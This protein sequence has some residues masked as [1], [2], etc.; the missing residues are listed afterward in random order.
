ME[1]S[2]R[3][4]CWV[5]NNPDAVA[6]VRAPTADVVCIPFRVIPERGHFPK[7]AAEATRLEHGNVFHDDIAGS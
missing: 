7:D 1:P 4:G 2:E 5:G 3:F 6:A